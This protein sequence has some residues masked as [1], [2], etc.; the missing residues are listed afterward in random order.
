M[1]MDFSPFQASKV[2]A[3]SD[4]E[5]ANAPHPGAK[6]GPGQGVRENER[7]NSAGAMVA[8]LPIAVLCQQGGPADRKIMLQR[9]FPS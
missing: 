2:D 5:K 1:L 3:G 6:H 7:G 8:A 4:I 9:S